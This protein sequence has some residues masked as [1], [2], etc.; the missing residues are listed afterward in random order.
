[1][2]LFYLAIGLGVLVILILQ[3]S[4]IG[5]GLPLLLSAFG[6]AVVTVAISS[7]MLPEFTGAPWVPTSSDRVR[8]VLAMSEL[9]ANELLYDLGSGDGR[10]VI[11]AARD[12]EARAIGIEID[13][14]RVLYSRLKILQFDLKDKVRIL[15]GN[16]FDIDLGEADVVVLF[17][18]QQTND[19]LRRKLERELTKPDC[20]V[21]SIVFQ[22]EGWEL[23]R[24][25]PEDMIYVYR[26]HPAIKESS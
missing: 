15:R 17:L 26:P 16:F 24:E 10:I 1:M 11:T 9:K 19:K 20:R 6:L 21:V 23:L 18:L 25:D 3:T 13:P 8:K 7:I 4:T 14:F 2:I 5:L 22:F 12:F